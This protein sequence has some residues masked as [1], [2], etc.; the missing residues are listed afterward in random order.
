MFKIMGLASAAAY[1][2]DVLLKTDTSENL[3]VA[4]GR[5][6]VCWIS[7]GQPPLRRSKTVLLPIAH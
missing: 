4:T 7:F 5:V 1:F 3:D 6:E 2:G